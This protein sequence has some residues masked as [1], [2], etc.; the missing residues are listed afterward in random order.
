MINKTLLLEQLKRFWAV[1]LVAGLLLF[2]MLPLQVFMM[3]GQ[4]NSWSLNWF[5]AQNL[6]LSNGP[7][8]IT[9]FALPLAAVFLTMTGFMR[10]SE[11]TAL[12]S[13]PAKKQA[14]HLT[15][16]LAGI[17]LTTLPILFVCMLLLVPIEYREPD[18]GVRVWYGGVLQVETTFAEVHFD[19]PLFPG[20][21]V[22]EGG[23]INT[24]PTVALLFVRMMLVALFNFAVFWL[25][26]SL[27]GNGIISLL[28]SGALMLGAFAFPAIANF[29]ADLYI[30]GAPTHSAVFRDYAHII[31]IPGIFWN[32]YSPHSVSA[33]VTQI[34]VYS[35]V[36]V[37]LGA[38][39]YITCGLRKAENTGNSIVFSPV[40]NILIFVVS[41]GIGFLA[42]LILWEVNRHPSS[43]YIGLFGGFAIG[44]FISQMIAEKSFAILHK[45]KYVA[46]F[47]GTFALLYGAFF[48]TTQFGLGFYVN[49]VPAEERI[50][51][52][53]VSQSVS[54]HWRWTPEPEVF[55]ATDP[56]VIRLAREAHQNI[57]AD[58]ANQRV[59]PWNNF[60][61]AF[62]MWSWQYHRFSIDY[63]LDNGRIIQRS[64]VLPVGFFEPAGLAELLMHRDIILLRH[65]ILSWHE[66]VAA[67]SLRHFS[68]EW[69]EGHRVA[70]WHDVLG[71]NE[72]QVTSPEGIQLVLSML[73]DDI[74]DDS[75]YWPNR[76]FVLQDAVRLGWGFVD[77]DDFV[78]HDFQWVPEPDA[79]IFEF[80]EIGIDIDWNWVHRNQGGFVWGFQSGWSVSREFFERVV[81]A[82][83]ELGYGVEEE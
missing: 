9:L 25:A 57:V 64:Y 71:L 50:V 46:H 44:Y 79:G 55:F 32:N 7:V 29:L 4:E 49:R 3:A 47:G 23:T 16:A 37:F 21:V 28:L 72:P 12:Y 63:L 69:W 81:E 68:E 65:Q 62:G 24:V 33:L 39:A 56:E 66:G 27:S 67:V 34:T 15:N 14:I 53:Y 41:W 58:R 77:L 18:G 52:V 51:G 73:Q 61:H 31:V 8:I 11:M 10:I 13:F 45:V 48:L 30:Y 38:L 80:F 36:A 6:R 20:D 26:F 42:G 17:I 75:R 40:K 1:P 22:V 2:F 82:L 19:G 5:L 76:L 35:L 59:N 83:R 43:F 60:R 78:E 70:T 54:R 74:V